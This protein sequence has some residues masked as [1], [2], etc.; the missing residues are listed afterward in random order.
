MLW[1]ATN[2]S[3]SIEAINWLAV[4]GAI[5][6]NMAVGAIWYSPIAMGN[7]WITSTGRTP[8]ELEGG[9]K[10]MATVIIPATLNVLILAVLAK[11]IGIETATQGALLGFLVWLGFVM[12][13]NWIEIIFDRKSYRTALI[14]NG[15]FIIT[16]P[17]MGAILGMWQ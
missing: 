12:P 13:T 5:I 6:G 7:A 14:N 16:F 9:G 17:L 2:M 1:G 11:M 15:N 3:I 8:E 10:A 4:L